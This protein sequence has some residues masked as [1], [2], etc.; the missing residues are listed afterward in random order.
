MHQ[1]TRQL[2]QT[3]LQQLG[4]HFQEMFY[5][6]ALFLEYLTLKIQNSGVDIDPDGFAAW[7]QA[8]HEEIQ[9][10]QAE[11]DRAA[12]AALLAEMPAVQLND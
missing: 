3:G 7:A 11:E 10:L 8:K 6:Q 2:I 5:K 12:A 4:S 1:Q 9:A